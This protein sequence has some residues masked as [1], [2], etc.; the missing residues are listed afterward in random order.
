MWPI[1]VGLY[2]L[3]FMADRLLMD[4]RWL[5]GAI[6]NLTISLALQIVRFLGITAWGTLTG[7]LF[8]FRSRWARVATILWLIV[9]LLLDAT[10]LCGILQFYSKHHYSVSSYIS[11]FKNELRLALPVCGLVG[12]VFTGLRRH[13]LSYLKQAGKDPVPLSYGQPRKDWL[14]FL[15][16]ILACDA[17][18][19]LNIDL[20]VQA[21]N[22]GWSMATLQVGHGVYPVINCFFGNAF[23]LWLIGCAFWLWHR[24]SQLR[25]VAMMLT[26]TAFV[27]LAFVN[28]LYYAIPVTYA[29][30]EY[31]NNAAKQLQSALGVVS[32]TCQF[33][34][35][36]LFALYVHRR[37][38]ELEGN[39]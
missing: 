11:A 18:E 12:F 19:Y 28:F 25:F 31:L 16:I 36:Y 35:L 15:I 4:S 24:P 5:V 17:I 10:D 21:W 8:L 22:K 38:R 2:L 26:I 30:P 29:T 27:F 37:D 1:L 6:A 39:V 34:V 33:L 7:F 3:A 23:A 14:V 9:I 13:S 20:L 32:G